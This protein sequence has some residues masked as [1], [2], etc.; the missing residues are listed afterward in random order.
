MG[1]KLTPPSQHHIFSSSASIMCQVTSFF[2]GCADLRK[3]ALIIGI[4]KLVMSIL[5][6]VWTV[7]AVFVFA[8]FTGSATVGAFAN[9][10]PPQ[11]NGFGN[12]GGHHRAVRDTDTDRISAGE[13]AAAVLVT[14]FAILGV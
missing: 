14:T 8:V 4:V 13:A 3:G 1:F 2:C 10:R 11:N 5:Q 7:L 12:G 6:V 9:A